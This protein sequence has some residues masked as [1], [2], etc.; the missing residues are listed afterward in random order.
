M[1]DALAA[2]GTATLASTK[3]S[4][5][6]TDLIGG[7]AVCA[8]SLLSEVVCERSLPSPAKW[9]RQ[10]VRGQMACQWGLALRTMELNS[11]PLGL[12]ILSKAT[13]SCREAEGKRTLNMARHPSAAEHP[14]SSP[15]LPAS[16]SHEEGDLTFCDSVYRVLGLPHYLV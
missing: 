4:L 15:L 2:S 10:V 5:D 8:A 13:V 6:C 1:E 3:C 12:S 14:C 11:S 7:L 16:T 9:L